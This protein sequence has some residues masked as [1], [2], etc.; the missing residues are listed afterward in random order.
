[1]GT[2]FDSLFKIAG[3]L[4][5]SKYSKCPRGGIGR[6]AWFRSMCREVWGFKS[7]RGHHI[8]K[9]DN[10]QLAGFLFSENL[11][12]AYFCFPVIRLCAFDMILPAKRGISTPSD[13]SC[14]P[15]LPVTYDRSAITGV[16]PHTV[17][18]TTYRYNHISIMKELICISSFTFITIENND[19]SSLILYR[20]DTHRT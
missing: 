9:N 17:I 14:H 2:L 6:R 16:F 10:P 8:R 5:N 20:P 4:Y 13:Y 11:A 3:N 1:M 7:L 18:F 12:F 19:I 15:V